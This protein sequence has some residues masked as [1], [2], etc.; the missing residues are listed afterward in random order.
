MSFADKLRTYRKHAG[1]SQEQL[2]EKLG[3]SRQAITKWETNSGLPDTEN[4]IAVSALLNITIDE[5]LSEK[6]ADGA[7][8]SS[9]GEYKSVTEY[10]VDRPKRFDIKLG[11]AYEV[12]LEGN[13]GEKFIICLSAD[14]PTLQSDFKIK[15]DDNKNGID[16]DLNRNNISQALAKQ[17]LKIAVVL[18]RKYAAAVEL[19]AV[20]ENLSLNGLDCDLEFDGKTKTVNINNLT[21]NT[22]INCNY[23][24]DIFCENIC[25]NVQINQL[26]STSRIHVPES[27]VFRA[28]KRGLG[29]NIYF[30]KCGVRCGAFCDD[31]ADYEIELNGVKSELLIIKD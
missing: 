15:I 1:L 25:G 19:S 16:A 29:N 21:G 11:A 23:D 27:P 31:K 12:T 17:K 9:D 18:P 22:E 20:T 5:L 10:D 8:H 14:I 24:M 26:S 2:A 7:I 13:D 28:V 6:N 30:E 3:V 4:L